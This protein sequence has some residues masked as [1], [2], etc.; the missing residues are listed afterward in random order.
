MIFYFIEDSED[1]SKLYGKSIGLIYG[2]RELLQ[3]NIRLFLVKY[4]K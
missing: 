1:L 2:S 4:G 3:E